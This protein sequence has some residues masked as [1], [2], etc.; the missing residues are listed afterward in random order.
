[1]KSNQSF[2]ATGSKLKKINNL[3]RSTLLDIQIN[4]S[5][6]AKKLAKKISLDIDMLRSLLDGEYSNKYPLEYTVDTFYKK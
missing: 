2:I 6:D 5:P 3:S 1:M 4:G